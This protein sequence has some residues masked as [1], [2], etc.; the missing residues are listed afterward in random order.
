M[1]NRLRVGTLLNMGWFVKLLLLLSCRTCPGKLHEQRKLASVQ[2]TPRDEFSA[3]LGFSGSVAFHV[4]TD[5]MGKTKEPCRSTT[6]GVSFLSPKMAQERPMRLGEYES[7][8]V[9]P[10]LSKPLPPL[11]CL[12][13]FLRPQERLDSI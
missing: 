6:P 4:G 5:K 12:W 11:K 3:S 10:M 13:G 9:W 1:G 7:N 8:E 2:V